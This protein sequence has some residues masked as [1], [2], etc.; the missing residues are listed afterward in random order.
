MCAFIA[1]SHGIHDYPKPLSLSF[2][3]ISAVAAASFAPAKSFSGVALAVFYTV[4]GAEAPPALTGY[5]VGGITPLISST[6]L[7]SSSFC[8][9]YF[10]PFSN[11]LISLILSRSSIAS[12]SAND[13]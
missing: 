12:F 6:N 10:G 4:L 5:L 2:L 7:F 9:G 11:L 3:L 1:A 8:T 13:G